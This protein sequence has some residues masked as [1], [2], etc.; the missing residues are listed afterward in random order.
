[1]EREEF[2]ATQLAEAA[3]AKEKQA[4]MTSTRGSGPA[5]GSQYDCKCASAAHEPAFLGTMRALTAGNPS[6]PQLTSPMPPPDRSTSIDT[7]SSSSS[8]TSS[9]AGS[10]ECSPRGPLHTLNVRMGALPDLGGPQP[11][12]LEMGSASSITLGGH[13]GPRLPKPWLIHTGNS[14]AHGHMGAGVECD[15]GSEPDYD[16][17]EEETVPLAAAIEAC[18]VRRVLSQYACTSS[19]CL[20]WA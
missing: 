12:A 16:S 6:K 14:L 18:V 4:N 5:G 2:V 19:A 11:S 15:A 20:R 9:D 13:R 10:A 17:D 3:A 7:A 8:D 1:M